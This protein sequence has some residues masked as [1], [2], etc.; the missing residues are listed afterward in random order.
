M[1]FC[2]YR[3]S[4]GYGLFALH[5]NLQ[6]HIFPS[7]SADALNLFLYSSD[8]AAHL[9]ILHTFCKASSRG[10]FLVQT[11]QAGWTKQMVCMVNA[12]LSRES[13]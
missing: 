13:P 10:V 6:C 3:N 5:C 2:L 8:T 9:G 1:C 7:E 11:K 4:I 12:F